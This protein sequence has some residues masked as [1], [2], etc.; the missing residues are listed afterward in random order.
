MLKTSYQFSQPI[1]P[2]GISYPADL[3]VRFQS[4][5]AQ[6]ARRKLN[7]SLVIDR[8][9]SM[10]GAPLQHAL[11]AAEAVVNRLEAD[12]IISIVV[13]DDNIDTIY[14]PSPVTDKNAVKDILRRVRAGG[15]T[16]LSGGW[17]KGC[18]HVKTNYDSQKVNRVMLLTD[19]HAN[20]GVTDL[21]TLTSTAGK[22]ASEGITTTTLGFG[23]GFNEDL[24]IGMAQAATGNYYF[25]QS[26]DE[27]SEVFTIELDSL[28][29]VVA[30]N[31]TAT[32]ELAAGVTLTDTLSLAKVSTDG[33]N[34]LL[35]L[36]DVYEGEDKL[37][38]LSLTL[39]ES[40]PGD[41]L[42][43]KLRFTADIVENGTTSQASGYTD[44]YVRIGTIEEASAAASTGILVELN[45]LKIAKT[46]ESALALLEDGKNADAEQVLRT[47]IRELESKGLNEN[48]E[49]AEEIEQL[50][51]FASQMA[52]KALGN[53]GRKELLD[54]SYQARNRNRADLGSRGVSAGDEVRSLKVV[55]EVGTGVELVCLREGGKL[56][57]KVL[58]DG[59]DQ[60]KNV[61]FPRAIRA[62][63]A[64]YVVEALETSSDGSFY[65]VVGEITR[66]AKAGEADV[67]AGYSSRSRKSSG[68]AKASA[69]APTAADLETTDT[70]G[71]WVL[72]Q[73]VKDGSKLR[74]RVVSDGYDPTWNMR[75]PRSIRE[76]GILYVV[77]EVN[78]AP[79]GKSY[80][81]CGDIKRFVQPT[82]TV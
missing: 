15:I 70:I 73:C 26:T 81:A 54:Q 68:S 45:R 69:G 35:A 5:L 72:V 6:T 8:S 23:R 77:E 52:N 57:I 36:G 76:E 82:V 20:A 44:I 47:L 39:P 9:G 14:G 7:I 18:E 19:G 80:I 13:Y 62:E 43:G 64:R 40:K 56:R 51:Y 30:Q 71:D 38:G 28:K 58:S 34:T 42:A 10:A 4:G 78:T 60:S 1:V 22:K 74:A 75:F 66:Y 17:L 2:E 41:V 21:K 32:L 63:G 49:I 31:L 11:K 12:D 37:L 24:L 46:K 65:R 50:H 25:I 61:Q 33:G 3:L 79:D 55:T 16:N 53:E 48:F 59:Y 27:A 67:F 29:S